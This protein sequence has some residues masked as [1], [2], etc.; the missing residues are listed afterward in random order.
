MNDTLG[1][2][3]ER[4][5]TVF[6]GDFLYQIR[7]PLFIVWA[8]VVIFTAWGMSSGAMKIQ[9]GDSTIGGTKSFVTSE[10]AGR[11]CSSPS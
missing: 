7:R 1:S 5:R 6:V 2:S 11:Q 10:F 9:S 8:L 3:I 4:I